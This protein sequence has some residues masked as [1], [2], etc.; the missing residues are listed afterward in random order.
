MVPVGIA[1]WENELSCVRREEMTSELARALRATLP[2]EQIAAKRFP[3][4]SR[5]V[6]VC[7]LLGIASNLAESV[8]TEGVRVHTVGVDRVS[9]DFYY[10][11]EGGQG[12]PVH[13]QGNLV[14]MLAPMLNPSSGEPEINALLKGLIDR[15]LYALSSGAVGEADLE[16][17]DAMP[18]LSRD[19]SGLVGTNLHA[20]EA[21]A[22]ALESRS[23]R[24]LASARRLVEA[25]S[26]AERM[27]QNR[28][29]VPL[30]GEARQ[31][32]S[33][34]VELWI[35]AMCLRLRAH[36]TWTVAG[37]PREQ[38]QGAPKAVEP[39]E[40]L[41][42][43]RQAQAQAPDDVASPTQESSADVP[44]PTAQLQPSSVRAGEVSTV[45]RH[46]PS[47]PPPRA[48]TKRAWTILLILLVVAAILYQLGR[49]FIWRDFE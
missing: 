14:E 1:R 11:A 36:S 19:G 25:L 2:H 20:F 12:E 48:T 32:A 16:L 47:A 28:V 43:P 37:T 3:M 24:H 46:V 39:L 4:A 41:V 7:P 35:G 33:E 6:E 44:E 22:R 23:A 27:G 42:V 45:P 10:F 13:L 18:R 31:E 30:Y 17:A 49:Q 21:R 38:P 9:A 40:S 34:P 15:I 5:A 26:A 8:R 29:E